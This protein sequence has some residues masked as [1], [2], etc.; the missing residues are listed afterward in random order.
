MAT[1]HAPD[2]AGTSPPP[3]GT[4]SGTGRW[5][6]APGLRMLGESKGSG[7]KQPTYLVRRG[8]GQVVQ[9]SE[10]LYHV[11]GELT[12]GRDNVSI[13]D[14]VS[15]SYGRTLDAEGLEFLL[16]ERLQPLGLAVDG[17]N[18]PEVTPAPVAKPLLSLTLRGRLM[19]ARTVRAVARH[20][21]FL[22]RPWFVALA[23][24]AF[25]GVGVGVVVRGDLLL[26]LQETLA[27]P[28]LLLALL[29]IL[30][31]GAIVHELGHAT[32]CRYGGAEPGAIGVGVYLVFPAFFTDVTESYRLGRGG[33]VR[34]DLGGLYFNVLFLV[35]AGGTYLAT[36]SG[37]VLLVILLML[38][39]MVQQLIP[40][41]RF[42]GYW[43]LSDLAGVP[44]LF[45]RVKPV[46]LS[47]LPGRPVDPTVADL[48]PASRRLV[49]GWVV[50]VVPLLAFGFGWLVWS[51]PTIVEQTL[52]ALDAQRAT[53]VAAWRTTD[54]VVVVLSVLSM[55]LLVL[56]LLGIAVLFLRLLR[57][58]GQMVGRSV[59]Y[60]RLARAARGSGRHASDAGDDAAEPP[61]EVTQAPDVPPRRTGAL[62][63]AAAFTDEDMLAPRPTPARQGWQA[64]VY[65][66]TRGRVSPRPGPAERRKLA[67]ESRLRSPIEGTRRVVVMS[68][69]GGVGKTTMT[70]AVGAT[71][72]L[73]RGDRVIAVD[74]NPDA[75]NLAHRIGRPNELSITDVL[76][77]TEEIDR[78]ATLRRYTTQA[79]DSRL[80]VLASDDNPHI[81]MALG[82]DDYHRLIELLDQYYNLILLDTG[83]GILDS[84]NQGLLTE[85]DQLVL[86]LRAGLDGGR[87]AALTLD[88]LD[89][90]HYE[91]LV[92][93]A[94]VVINGVRRGVGAPLEPM[95][96][97]FLQRCAQVVTVPWDKTLEAGALTL[98]GDLQPATRDALTEVAAAVADNFRQR[99]TKR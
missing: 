43:I 59:W 61:E 89:E 73:T 38:L 37:L 7:F 23:L 46:L 28:V 69:K 88:W 77:A 90:H 81:E 87:A 70:Y 67:I 32:A 9:V 96:D 97:H 76:A 99:G 36:G 74:A 14:A 8:D 40:V 25:V 52:A 83:T 79:V 27:S 19:P 5:R 58:V 53:L 21:T 51:T 65:R 49:V 41:V 91:D 82:R 48:R 92:Q 34:T 64:S 13:A 11:V 39:E 24:V 4:A 54:V 55:L 31:A 1:A 98:F 80:E 10:L 86:V 93:N 78:Y 60:R 71:F 94:V 44:D 84:A 95:T 29:G 18:E 22:Y 2:V 85:A 62:L 72:A 30:T 75:G 6:R 15:Q 57:T 3:A 33:R 17:D 35:V 42:D 45:A 68:R 47:A 56:P 63:T 12:V 66:A 26:A 20:L 50:V 16:R